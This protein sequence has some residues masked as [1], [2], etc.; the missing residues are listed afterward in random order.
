MTTKR[1]SNVLDIVREVTQTARGY[2]DITVWW[3]VPR[4]LDNPRVELVLE[5]QPGAN[6]PFERI[7]ADV[8]RGLNDVTVAARAHGPED[9]ARRLFRILT[10]PQA[11]HRAP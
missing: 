6:P 10:L 11:M 4:L 9:A 5:V 3:Y 8:Q 1:R 2:P 7:A